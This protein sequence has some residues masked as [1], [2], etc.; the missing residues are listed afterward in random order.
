MKDR[1]TFSISDI[2]DI[3]G[4]DDYSSYDDV[5]EVFHDNMVN[6]CILRMYFVMHTDE[7]DDKYSE[8]LRKF[9]DVY[10]SLSYDEQQEVK[11]QLIELEKITDEFIENRK[12]KTK[13]NRKNK[14]NFRL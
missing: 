10:D 3:I 2:I 14:F 7:K 9:E 8:R 12:T 6:E 4:D 5:D 13:S 1:L 11:E